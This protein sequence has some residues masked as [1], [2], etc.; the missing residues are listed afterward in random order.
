[1]TNSEGRAGAGA[2]YG[3]LEVMILKTLADGGP[4]H[5][6]QVATLIKE[7]SENLLTV[8]EGALYPALHRL[9]RQDLIEGE[10]RISDKRRRARFYD[11]TPRGHVALAAELDT[12]MRHA[13]AVNKVLGIEE[14]P[15]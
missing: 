12:W 9:K 15:S 4:L 1:M 8:E 13:G 10:W 6:L 3:T 5:G 7:R 14:V 11:L 2:L